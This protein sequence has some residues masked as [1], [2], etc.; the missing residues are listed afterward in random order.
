MTKLQNI[1]QITH[2]DAIST[3]K[4]K[5]LQFRIKSKAGRS[6]GRIVVKN[7]SL[8]NKRLYRFIDYKRVILPQSRALILREYYVSISRRIALISFTQGV[9]TH[10]ILPSKINSVVYNYT[11]SPSNPGDSAQL[12]YLTSGSLIH[13]ISLRPMGTGKFIRS[14]GCSAI[15]VRKDKFV[16]LL[17]LKSGELRYFNNFNT[18]TLGS[19]GNET[20]F[21][22]DL[23]KAGTNRYLGKRP[24]VRP[25]A[26]NPVDHPMGGRTK[27][28]CQPMNPHGVINKNRSTKR[29]YPLSIFITK[30]QLKFRRV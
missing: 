21:L 2:I 6:H 23:K 13:N 20:H 14:A 11:E 12:Q 28:G 3:D 24:R 1:T 29:Y 19:V 5:P 4:F 25:S 16:S 10:I 27:G 7:R 22:R 8:L 18:A 30:R 26:M 17:K 9:F 15:L